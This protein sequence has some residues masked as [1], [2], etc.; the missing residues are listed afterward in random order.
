M[1]AYPAELVQHHYA[2]MLVA[3]LTGSPSSSQ[4]S[5]Q[6]PLAQAQ[7]PPSEQQHQQAQ[8]S[9]TA[10]PAAAIN[11]PGSPSSSPPRPLAPKREEA[12]AV[13]QE[14]HAAPTPT[15]TQAFPELCRDLCEVFDSR[16][17][18][19]AWDP[20]KGQ[21]AVFHSVLVDAVGC[22]ISS[23]S[24]GDEEKKGKLI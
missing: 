14:G 11:G 1:N 7:V 2:C 19:T 13:G 8:S 9:T 4:P 3:G 21:S 17:R 22:Q 10:A 23:S 18:G 12:A 5:S 15:P 6:P 20:A 24:A 16:G